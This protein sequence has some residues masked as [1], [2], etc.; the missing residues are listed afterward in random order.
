MIE[1][2]V[3]PIAA[4]GYQPTVRAYS[5]GNG[6]TQMMKSGLLLMCL[7]ASA[8]AATITGA[9]YANTD[10]IPANG[11]TLSGTFTNVHL[12]QVGAGSTVFVAAG[13]NLN[14]YATTIT[15]TGVL[16]GTGRGQ[17]GGNG[18]GL[19]GRGLSG[20]AGD[21]GDTGGGGGG[22]SP[23][24]G[25]GGGGGG[26]GGAGA[27]DSGGGFGA[28]GGAAYGSTG[29]IAGAISADDLFQGSGGG[30]GGGSASIPGGNGAAG[31]AAIYMEASS[32]TIA[33]S[34]MVDGSTGSA[35]TS[36]SVG[37]FPGAGGGGGGGTLL[38]RIP[39]NINI[40]SGSK[41]S[42]KGGGGANVVALLGGQ[43]EPGGGGAGGRLKIFYRPGTAFSV[44]LSTFA[45][46]AGIGPGGSVDPGTPPQAGAAGAVSFGVIASSPSGLGVSQVNISSITWGWTATPSFGDELSAPSYRLFP[47]TV[48][49]PYPTP[50]ATVASPA[51]STSV[52]NLTP[53]TTYYRFVTAFT[54]WG[55]SLPSNGVSTHTL[56]NTPVPNGFSAMAD[57][58]LTANWS[59]GTPSN[60]SYTLYQTDRSTN[61]DF[62]SAVFT[63][64]VTA[65][66]STPAVLIPN[67]TYYFRARAIN[68]DGVM[69]PFTA[70]FAT[71]TLASAPA[72]PAFTM[73]AVTSVSFSWSIGSNPSDT[74]YTAQFSTNNFLTIN[75]SSFTLNNSALFSSGLQPGATYYFRVRSVNRN[76]VASDFTTVISTALGNLSDNS[77][78]SAPGTPQPDRSFSRD[79][80]VVFSWSA[81]QSSAGILD[82]SLLIGST[83]GGNDVFAGSTNTISYRVTGLLSGK[84]YYAQVA[85]RSNAGVPGPFSAVSVGVPVFLTDQIP[86]LAK[87]INWPNPFDPRLGPT[88]IAFSLDKSAVVI[89]KIYTLQGR[90]VHQQSLD[91]S[92]GNQIITW[93]GVNDSGVRV[94]P[95]GYIA[96]IRKDYSGRIETQKFKIAVLY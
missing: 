88:N 76:S 31:G 57:T 14:I 2:A 63:N 19:S 47:A 80:T 59:A 22:A 39:G 77:A 72:S 50:E 1:T 55:D 48:T 27:G 65:L 58:T 43:V 60:P 66:S 62:S 42:A 5:C 13:V 16:D 35:V 67:T 10:L 69:T 28:A 53:N 36:G 93:Y 95:G 26:A 12:F 92:V 81:S 73:V 54:A 75:D 71:A 87:P 96:V 40:F 29:T 84:T 30:G 33:G 38:L 91:L 3:A 83:P 11:D 9:D 49:A 20:F 25:G 61:S 18:G 4:A 78:P 44:S 70:V 37:T 64:F 68:L 17:S 86:A 46:P 7:A 74:I 41:L 34:I 23:K 51:V 56:A 82:Y 15:I 8:G 79:G 85:A 32:F 89:L 21:P 6:L 94:A 52:I 45:G 90:L 24:G